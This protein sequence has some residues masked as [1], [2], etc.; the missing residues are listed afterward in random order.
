MGI[1]IRRLIIV[2][3]VIVLIPNILSFFSALTNGLPKELKEKVNNGDAVLIDLD[4]KVDFEN[5][6]ILFKHL[7]LAPD[8]TSLIFEVNPNENG[9]SFPD[10][11]LKLKDN[12]GNSY[13]RTSGSSSHY[14][15]GQYT[16]NHYEPLAAGVESIVLEFE[17]FDRMVQTEFSLN[18]EGVQ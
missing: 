9:W 3:C 8:E 6:E 1:V 11:A 5:D 15:G 2:A 10:S 7:V 12:Q 14:L 13:Q 18:Q 4:K 17:W 16:I